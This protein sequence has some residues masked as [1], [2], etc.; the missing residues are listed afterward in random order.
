M[1]FT[2]HV[3]LC[4]IVLKAM[5]GYW[6]LYLIFIIFFTTDISQIIFIVS[7]K[8]DVVEVLIPIT[9][10]MYIIGNVLEVM[11]SD[12]DSLKYSINPVEENLAIIISTWLDKHA[13][14]VTCEVLLK[15]VEGNI[16]ETQQTEQN[17]CESIKKHD[18]FDRYVYVL[19]NHWN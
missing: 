1:P 9:N 16:V 13:E 19:S 6:R 5:Y 12:L 10:K 18:V 14:E 17:V 8:K 3:I 7:T 11:L 4:F 2:S 15:A